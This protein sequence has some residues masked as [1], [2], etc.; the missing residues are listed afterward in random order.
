MLQ[1]VN[2]KRISP[3]SASGVRRRETTIRPIRMLVKK[4]AK[5]TPVRRKT[6]RFD[7][8]CAF[9]MTE[10]SATM[11]FVS[12]TTRREIVRLDESSSTPAFPQRKPAA[13][14]KNSTAILSISAG[15]FISTSFLRSA[16]WRKDI[17]CRQKPAGSEM[18][19]SVWTCALWKTGARI[20]SQ[21]H[22][23]D[24]PGGRGNSRKV[25]RKM[26]KGYC[27]RPTFFL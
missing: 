1:K 23:G 17:P 19:R 14:A 10:L 22:E 25:F 13:I 20:L 3:R 9:P 2:K 18:P 12:L 24:F 4:S 21:M 5:A 26:R 27:E 15:K 11:G 16:A 8:R 6:C 7:I